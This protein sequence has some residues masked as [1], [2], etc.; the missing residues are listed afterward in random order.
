MKK[1][2]E[3]EIRF[4]IIGLGLMGREFG[5]ALSR[6]CGL[7]TPP[8]KPV[9]TAVCNKS[10]SAKMEWF[11]DNF[12]SVALATNDYRELIASPDV[13]AVYCAVPHHLHEKVFIDILESGKHLFGEKPF[14][15]DLEANRRILTAVEKHQELIVRCT[16]EYPYFPGAM[17]IFRWLQTGAYGRIIES[18]AGFL[19]SSDLDL[20]KKINWKRRV[21]TNGEYGCMGDLGMHLLH[22]PLRAGWQAKTVFADLRQ[23]VG[24][25]PG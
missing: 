18:R 7:T 19:H 17:R 12:P 16:S 9:I 23:I 2:Y 20:T 11:T 24:S 4:G 13:D 14:G 3:Q 6:W 8:P 22:I 15:I 5:S 1:K 21:E 25:R 10:D